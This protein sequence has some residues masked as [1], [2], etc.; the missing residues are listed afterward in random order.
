MIKELKDLKPTVDA[1]ETGKMKASRGGVR[2]TPT[3]PVEPVDP[4]QGGVHS[5]GSTSTYCYCST[6]L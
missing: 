4:T 6:P 5:G 1:L 3:A 2:P